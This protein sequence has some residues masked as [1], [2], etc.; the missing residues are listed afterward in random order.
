[1]RAWKRERTR[2][3]RDALVEPHAQSLRTTNSVSGT[4]ASAATRRR[5]KTV[6]LVVA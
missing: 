1:M 4:P 5:G 2:E 6:L 3:E